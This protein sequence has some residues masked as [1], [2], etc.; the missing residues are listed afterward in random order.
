MRLLRVEVAAVFQ[1]QREGQTQ[2]EIGKFRGMVKG[3]WNK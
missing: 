1:L 3:D 2:H